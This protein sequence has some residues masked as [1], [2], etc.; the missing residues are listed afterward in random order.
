MQKK[1]LYATVEHKCYR[2]SSQ[3]SNEVL[4]IQCNQEEA[5][6]RLHLHVAREGY[7]DV[8]ICSEDKDVFT[9]ALAFQDKISTHLFQRR[10]TK[11]R[12]R[13]VDIKKVAATH[14]TD[15]CKAL[16]G[17]HATVPLSRKLTTVCE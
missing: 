6:G 9:L 11:T 8:V 15:V 7:G 1:I 2:I 12:K 10:G 16:I 14:G 13:L 4:F 5:D 3:R 17:M